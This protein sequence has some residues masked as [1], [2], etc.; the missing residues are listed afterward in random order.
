MEGLAM[1]KDVAAMTAALRRL[2]ARIGMTREPVRFAIERSDIRRYALACGETW[3]A[4]VVGDEAPPTFIAALQGEGMGH[5]L[6][7]MDLP[8]A[9]FLH[10]NDGVELFRPIRPGDVLTGQSRYVDA[11]LREGTT[12]PMLFQTATMQLTD[13]TCASV[14]RVDTS[15]VSF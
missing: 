11:F 15:V 6:F 2:R 8:C 1:G 12:G 3:P 7:D 10:S 13:E 9:M 14:A 4:Y 5:G